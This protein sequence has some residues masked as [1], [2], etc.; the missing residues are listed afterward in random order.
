MNLEQTAIDLHENAINKGFYEDNFDI[1]FVLGKLAL[2]HSEVSEILEAIR[3]EQGDA[4]VADEFA[5]VFIRTLDL[6]AALKDYGWIAENIDIE[7]AI[8]LKAGVNKT[9]PQKH[10]V[11]A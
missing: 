3:K 9:R 8:N 4:K 6:W 11:L 1:H 7:D 2:I 5:D 10:G